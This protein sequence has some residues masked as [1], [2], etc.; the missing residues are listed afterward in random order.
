[1]SDA[2]RLEPGTNESVEAGN[3]S[4]M[5]VTEAEAEPVEDR[6]EDET[7]LEYFERLNEEAFDRDAY[8]ADSRAHMESVGRM[9]DGLMGDPMNPRDGGRPM[10]AWV[11]ADGNV[12]QAHDEA[13]YGLVEDAEG[14]TEYV[15]TRNRLSQ[16]YRDLRQSEGLPTDDRRGV[17]PSGPAD[18][19]PRPVQRTGTT[20]YRSGV[21][22]IVGP[23][24][25]R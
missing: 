19:G 5:L 11:A 21:P 4:A 13:Y 24:I 18:G 3:G 10:N 9:G 25:P 22:V 1:M 15:T 6:R 8:R 14:W 7:P 12:Y 17:N 16:W 23:T 2:G 20:V